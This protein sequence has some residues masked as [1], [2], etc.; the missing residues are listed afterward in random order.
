M[1]NKVGGLQTLLNERVLKLDSLFYCVRESV[2]EGGGLMGRG[3]YFLQCPF[4]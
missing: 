4:N 3:F 1:A 2:P